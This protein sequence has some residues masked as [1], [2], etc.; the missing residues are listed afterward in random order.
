MNVDNSFTAFFDEY[1]SGMIDSAAAV[2]STSGRRSRSP[3]GRRPLS[4]GVNAGAPLLGGKGGV[5]RL[6]LCFSSFQDRD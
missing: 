3:A 2:A 5:V 1:T 4:A 6:P